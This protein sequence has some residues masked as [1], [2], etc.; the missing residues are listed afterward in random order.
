VP[1]RTVV[2]LGHEHRGLPDKAWPRLDEVV[3]IPLVG[4]DHA[5]NLLAWAAPIPPG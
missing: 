2:L 5:E 1:R 4:R 3:V